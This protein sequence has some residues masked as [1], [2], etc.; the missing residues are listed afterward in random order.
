M[1]TMEGGLKSARGFSPA[2]EIGHL[3]ACTEAGRHSLSGDG[4]ERL[5]SQRRF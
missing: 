5:R 3:G 1:T 4:A 2:L